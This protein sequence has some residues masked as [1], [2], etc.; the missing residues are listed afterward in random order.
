M[1]ITVK[2][3]S[4]T[5]VAGAN[6]VRLSKLILSELQRYLKITRVK[7]ENLKRHGNDKWK[8]PIPNAR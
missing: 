5:S 1:R 6:I 3:D 8:N 2:P 4:P 7:I